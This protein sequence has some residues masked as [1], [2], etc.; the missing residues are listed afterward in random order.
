M[1]ELADDG[2]SSSS[3]RSVRN[4]HLMEAEPAVAAG[5]AQGLSAA[6]FGAADAT[7]FAAGPAVE[8]IR[9]VISDSGVYEVRTTGGASAGSP[10]AAPGSSRRRLLG[11]MP[12]GGG[13][14]PSASVTG[15]VYDVATGNCSECQARP[16]CA[17]ACGVFQQL[18]Q[19]GL[20]RLAT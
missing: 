15:V 9:I 10:G 14:R 1:A 12:P 7:A 16:A 4:A 2:S 18:C 8:L 17:C 6:A 5:P 20:R 11:A 19:L 3:S 13:S